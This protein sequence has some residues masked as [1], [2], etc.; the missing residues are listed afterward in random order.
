MAL[1][2]FLTLLQAALFSGCAAVMDDADTITVTETPLEDLAVAATRC[3]LDGSP[4][5]RILPFALPMVWRF[6]T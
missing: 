1:V 6:S 4:T 5:A 3:E 2:V